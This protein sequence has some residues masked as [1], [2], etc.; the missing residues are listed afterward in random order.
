MRLMLMGHEWAWISAM[1]TKCDP[2][3]IAAARELRDRWL[4]KVNSGEH[5]AQELGKYDVSRGLPGSRAG[6]G[7]SPLRLTA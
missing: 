4:E 7:E 2:K 3:L 5:L 1:K 6:S